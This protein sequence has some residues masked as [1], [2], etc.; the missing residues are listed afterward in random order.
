MGFGHDTVAAELARRA[1][2]AGWHAE[3]ADVLGLLPYASGRALRLGYRSAVR[4]APWA[5]AGVYELFLRPREGP[6]PSISPLTSLAA[7]RLLELVDR[8]RADLVVPVFHV[9]AQLTGALRERGALTVPSA[10]V[11]TDFVVHRQW[12][13]PGN[14]LHLVVSADAAREVSRRTAGPVEASGPLVSPAFLEP[15]PRARDWRRDFERRAPGRTPVLLSTGAW[16]VGS[17][18]DGTARLLARRGYLPVL[19]CGRN[20]RLLRRART[21]PGSLALGWVEDM[22]GLMAAAGALV[23]NAAGQTAVQALA[24][25]LPVVG[26]RPIPGHGAAGVLRMADL[27]LTDHVRDEGE[28]LGA[29]SRLAVPGPARQQ[30]VAAGRAL[31][32]G[33]VITPLTRLYEDTAPG[34]P[35]RARRH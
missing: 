17:R 35:A 22:P 26:H 5:Y 34:R 6:R 32:T 20:E 2:R 25:G 23:D 12:L 16:G 30:R 14:D 8:T 13:H 18:L 4:Y 28:L 19:L 3:V 24:A 27:G 15:A 1:R 31:F 29:L 21:L 10:V 33:D 11:V 9:A 7:R